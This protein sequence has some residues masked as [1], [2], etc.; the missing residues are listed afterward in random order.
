MDSLKSKSVL[1]LDWG[2]SVEMALKLAE[3][4]GKVYYYTNWQDAA[5]TS[6]KALIG[7]G[8]EKFGVYKVDYFWDYV[9]KVDLICFFDTYGQD[10]IE[11]LRK[12]GYRVFGAGLA[13]FLETN[14]KYGREIQKSVELPAQ[15]TDTVV[16]LKALTDEIKKGGNCYVKLNTFRGDIETFFAKDYPS[17]KI[18]LD[19]LSVS[20][21]PRQESV[22]F[23]LEKKI[24]GVEPGYDGFVVDG[25]YTKYC[26]W[27]YERKESGYIGKVVRH[28]DLPPAIKNVNDKLASFFSEMKTRSFF[29]SE[30]IVDTGGQGYLI[31][32]TVRCPMPVGTALHLELWENLAEFIWEASVGNI[33]DLKPLFKYGCGTSLCSDWAEDNFMEVTVDPDVRRFVKMGC[34]VSYDDKYFIVPALIKNPVCTVIGLGDTVDEAVNHL[35]ENIKGVS[36]FELDSDTGG[37][38]N[39]LRDIQE[40]AEYGLP[41]FT[42]EV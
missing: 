41:D 39:I 38:E 42:A 14:R 22:E 26:M 31:D 3:K 15:T 37:I 11:Y 33:I 32:P 5:P 34:L 17:S 30:I 20:L 40:G 6:G 1:V 29:S 36:G 10:I 16:G 13:E 25:Q 23:M 19:K 24:E 7:R 9:D 12:K 21:G 4:F 27:G 18:Y 35:R 28:D 8:L 2:M